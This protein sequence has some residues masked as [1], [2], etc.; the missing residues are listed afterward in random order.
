MAI[1]DSSIEI[2]INLELMII[3]EATKMVDEK[4]ADEPYR[5]NVRMLSKKKPPISIILFV[6]FLFNCWLALLRTIWFDLIWYSINMACLNVVNKHSI[7]QCLIQWF[8][9]FVNVNYTIQPEI[10]SQF[11]PRIWTSL[12]WFAIADGHAVF[13]ENKTIFANSNHAKR[14]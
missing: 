1:F 10:A 8:F 12:L 4:V 2:I 13:I 9:F 6:I 5:H 11:M 3:T 14:E 7:G